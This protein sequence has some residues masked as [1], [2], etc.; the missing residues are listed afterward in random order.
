MGF[1]SPQRGEALISLRI[2]CTDS[3]ADQSEG[4]LLQPTIAATRFTLLQLGQGEVHPIC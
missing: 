3:S 4:S 1:P 2:I